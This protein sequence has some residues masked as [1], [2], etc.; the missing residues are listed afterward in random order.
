MIT[1]QNEKLLDLIKFSYTLQDIQDIS[2]FLETQQT[3]RFPSLE[4]GLF[5]ASAVTVK[6]EYTGYAN[7]WIRDNVYVA[8]CHYLAGLTTIAIKNLNTLMSYFNKH[9]F[10]FEEI[11][12]GK[13]DKNQVME[14]PH[15]RFDGKNLQEVNQEWNH[16]QNDALGYFLWFYCKLISIGLLK[17][18][19]EEWEILALFPLYFQAIGYW[20]DSDSGHWEEDRKI[21]ASS[22]GVV[23][24]ALK[25]M[26]KLLTNLEFTPQCKYRDKVITHELLDELIDIGTVSLNNILPWECIQPGITRRY[27]AVLLFLIYPLEIIDH[28]IAEQILTDIKENLQGDFGIR[29]YL[30]D[31]FWC[32]DYEDIPEA[33]RTDVSSKREQWFKENNR[34]LN[35]GEEAQWNIFDPIISA[36]F[37]QRYQKTSQAEYLE[38]QTHYFNRSLGQLTP[39][40]FSHGELRC[41]ELYYLQ[42][43]KY[44]PNDS[45][46]LLWTQANLNIALVMMKR[47]LS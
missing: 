5:P 1:I 42:D 17:P 45:T 44:I 22:I 27:D 47:S 21:S 2:T 4:N 20:E 37:G 39:R 26:K 33:I 3:L 29:R 41:P 32:K 28:A 9:K 12:E 10:R 13:A 19:S 46:P 11:I 24:A 38:Q 18:K 23:V 8:Y 7:V 15:I 31:S 34:E 36:I 6:T 30:E 14:R 35:I 25:E 43:G 40:Y 16:A